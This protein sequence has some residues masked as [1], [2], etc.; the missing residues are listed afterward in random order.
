MNK[1]LLL[2][3]ILIILIWSAIAKAEG[4]NNTKPRNL[5]LYKFDSFKY[6]GGFRISPQM[7]GKHQ[8]ATADFSS[9]VFTLNSKNNSIF[10]VGNPY[11][12]TIAE[13]LIP[14]LVKSNN[15]EDFNVANNFIQNFTKIYKT[16]RVET[17]VDK[18]FRISGL[19]I[20]DNAL[21]VNYFN[22]YD[23]SN[24]V[25]HT[26][27]MIKDAD[28]IE[29]SKIYGPYQLQGRSHAAGSISKIPS[30]WQKK[31]GGTHISGSPSKA[32][33]ISRLSVGPTAFI[34]NPQKQNLDNSIIPT[35]PL[36]DFSLQNIL[37]DSSKFK[38]PNT[39]DI[40]YNKSK[41]NDLW[42]IISGASFGF[43]IPESNTYMTIG[44]SGGH[45][46]GIGYKI[47][48]DTGKLCS[49][50]CPFEHKDQYSYY[51]AWDINDLL[52]VKSGK[53]KPFEVR[54]YAYGKIQIPIDVGSAQINGGAF[55]EES[56]TLYLSIPIADKVHRF[57]R[58]PII[59]AFKLNRLHK[60]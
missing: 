21:W 4:I 58:P 28:N 38:T 47:T 41:K 6:S 37:Y 31:L 13:L 52:K 45:S 2:S 32:S 5:P 51:W 44:Y 11:D 7:Q 17:G 25:K 14:E 3:T 8:W 39:N 23:A 9:G 46:S 40:L 33:I 50:P 30:H 22:W 16:S 29:A 15:I 59:I 18:Y 42:T 53:I 49:G 55:D 19:M 35:N 20:V 1:F 60:P 12:G 56:E 24:K 43:I 48:Q 26:T 57:K 10:L 54:P 36:L 27:M 34:F